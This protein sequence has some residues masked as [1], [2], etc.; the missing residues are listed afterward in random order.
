MSCIQNRLAAINATQHSFPSGILPI[1]QSHAH[2]VF[3]CM[4]AWT[5][6]AFLYRYNSG[7]FPMDVEAKAGIS[8]KV[9]WCCKHRYSVVNDE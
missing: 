7:T 8:V 2:G 6:F 1:L 4:A 3:V 9:G 5:L